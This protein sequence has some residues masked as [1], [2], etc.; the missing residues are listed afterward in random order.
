MKPDLVTNV[1]NQSSREGGRPHIMVLHTTEG[2]NQPGLADL[3]SLEAE[4]NDPASQ[5][6]SHMATDGDGNIARYVPDKNKAW[7]VC[8][9]NP[10]SLNVEQVGFA[11]STRKE[12][13][14]KPLQLKA[15]AVILA[16]WSTAWS[17][18]LQPAKIGSGLEIKR[19]GVCQHKDLGAI[20]CGHTDC[21]P[22]YP[23]GYVT[24]LAQLIVEEHHN[25][26]PESR[27]A[28]R[29]RFR[30]NVTRKRYGLSLLK[31]HSG[32]AG[33]KTA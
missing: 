8:S 23:Q 4:F 19:D 22:G 15:A 12:W 31:S 6:S 14:E 26:R 28:K 5:A 1:A 9:F 7:S 18:P 20:G 32:I 16:E 11:S 10:Y 33:T 3:E 25:K 13:F 17:I 24:R 30:L 21:G 2:H 29:L 27:K